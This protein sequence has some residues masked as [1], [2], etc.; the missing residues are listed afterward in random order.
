MTRLGVYL[1]DSTELRKPPAEREYE[2]IGVYDLSQHRWT[3][4]TDERL[5]RMFSSESQEISR[6][7]MVDRVET[8]TTQVFVEGEVPG[9][10]SESV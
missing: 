9:S 7:E 10:V 8:A 2:R 3:D 6:E 5:Q 4:N 1:V